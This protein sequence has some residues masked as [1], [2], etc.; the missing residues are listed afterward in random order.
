MSGLLRHLATFVPRTGF[1]ID[2]GKAI[3]FSLLCF[4]SITM[5]LCKNNKLHSTSPMLQVWL[6]NFK[7]ILCCYNYSYFKSF[8]GH[9]CGG[10]RYSGARML[11]A[12]QM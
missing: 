8:V 10:E 3:S 4:V 7:S 11:E 2:G 12:F 5:C 9:S 1:L 6:L